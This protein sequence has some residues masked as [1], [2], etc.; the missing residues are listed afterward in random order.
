VQPSRHGCAARSERTDASRT[1]D[2]HGRGT[3]W[4]VCGGGMWQPRC[5][6]SQRTLLRSSVQRQYVIN[7]ERTVLIL[8]NLC[9]PSSPFFRFTSHRGHAACR[10]SERHSALCATAHRAAPRPCKSAPPALRM[11]CWQSPATSFTPVPP[12]SSQ[13]IMADEHDDP[14]EVAGARRPQPPSIRNAAD[15]SFC[16]ESMSLQTRRARGWDEA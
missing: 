13:E 1:A 14:M 5:S 11:R 9:A 15:M 12:S 3:G 4:C 16:L 10:S 2:A 6:E 8:R 7:H